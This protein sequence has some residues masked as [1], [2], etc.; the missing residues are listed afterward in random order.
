MFILS[1]Y[2][3]FIFISFLLQLWCV[4]SVCKF[5]FLYV[6]NIIKEEAPN[7][8][9]VG[10]EVFLYYLS[11]FLCATWYNYRRG[12]TR[13]HYQQKNLK[14]DW[15]A[16]DYTNCSWVGSEVYIIFRIFLWTVW[17][18]KII[19]IFYG[20]CHKANKLKKKMDRRKKGYTSIN[21]CCFDQLKLG[22][23][24]RHTKLIKFLLFYV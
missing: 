1:L 17:Y 12:V 23:Y 9:W 6:F 16:R 15:I 2:L 22:T 4:V 20:S 8:S 24:I 19:G 14:N 7:G 3:Y 11:S 18:G 13:K 10:W 21:Y 5:L